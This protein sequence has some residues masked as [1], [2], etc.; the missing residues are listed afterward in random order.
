MPNT[1]FN[2][3]K[4]AFLK[5]KKGNFDFIIVWEIFDLLI[6][7][8]KNYAQDGRLGDVYNLNFPS[9]FYPLEYFGFNFENA[10]NLE[11][12]QLS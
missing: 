7:A 8:T 4:R 5:F 12:S 9:T 2:D 10:L 1:P 6:L 11:E 3:K